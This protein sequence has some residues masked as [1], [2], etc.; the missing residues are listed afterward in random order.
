MAGALEAKYASLGP[1]HARN[2][3]RISLL[4]VGVV[5]GVAFAFSENKLSST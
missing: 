4:N 3:T 5:P 1:L 2:M